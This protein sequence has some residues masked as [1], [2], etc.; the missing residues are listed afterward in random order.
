MSK[1]VVSKDVSVSEA[2]FFL[3]TALW[4]EDDFQAYIDLFELNSYDAGYSDGHEYGKDSANEIGWE[5]EY[6]RGFDAG[7]EEGYNKG[8]DEAYKD[9]FQDGSRESSYNERY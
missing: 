5:K 3:R 7:Y 8:S 1:P 2:Y 9:G 6:Q 4:D